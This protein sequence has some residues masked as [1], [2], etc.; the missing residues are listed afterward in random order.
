[1]IQEVF[2][3]IQESNIRV[4]GRARFQPWRLMPVGN[5][6]FFAKYDMKIQKKY[7]VYG[8]L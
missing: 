3:N 5:E 4:K 7:Q 8:V 2:S 1:M 6:H